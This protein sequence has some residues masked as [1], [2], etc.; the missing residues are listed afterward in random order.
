MDRAREVKKFR[1]F[2]GGGEGKETPK[3]TPKRPNNEGPEHPRKR[4]PIFLN[5]DLS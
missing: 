4:K 1:L 5:S 3:E 2:P